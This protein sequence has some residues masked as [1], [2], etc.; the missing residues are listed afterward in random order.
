M[1][2]RPGGDGPDDPALFCFRRTFWTCSRTRS[3]L[4][5]FPRDLW[6]CKVMFV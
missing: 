6:A 2:E 5:P 3:D 1:P 4:L